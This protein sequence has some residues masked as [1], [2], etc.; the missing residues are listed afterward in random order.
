M[1]ATKTTRGVLIAALATLFALL[2]T[3]AASAIVPGGLVNAGCVVN[4]GGG[5]CGTAHN[6]PSGSPPA[7]A[8]SP[9]G[10]NV[11]VAGQDA[12]GGY[13]LITFARNPATG[14]LTQLG[15]TAGCI[16][17]T[18]ITNVCATTTPALNAPSSI[19]ITPDGSSVYVA[20]AG[21]SNILEFD[22]GAGGVLSLKSTPCIAN[23]GGPSQTCLDA[24]AMS[25]PQ[26]LAVVGSQL[27][28]VSSGSGAVTAL[29][30]NGGG[31]LTQIPTTTLPSGCVSNSLLDGCA[32]YAALGG[33]RWIAARPDALYVASQT[34]RTIAVIERDPSTGLMAPRSCVSAANLLCA[35]K[36]PADFN[37]NLN[38]LV[39]SPGGQ[40]YASV[41]SGRVVA[42]DPT[43]GPGLAR[44]AGAGGCVA[45]AA[46]ANSCTAGRQFASPYALLATADGEDV[47][48]TSANAILEL[49]RAADGSI[50][51]RPDNRGCL[52]S[53]ATTSLC[54]NTPSLAPGTSAATASRDDHFLYVVASTG[55]INAFKRDSSSPVCGNATVTVNVGFQGPL[56]IP[57]SDE[58]GDPLS[59]S[60]VNAPTLG[61]TGSIDNAAAKI[62]YSAPAAQNGTTTFTIRAAYTSFATFEAIGSITVNVVGAPALVPAGVD[63][64]KDGFFAG[65][66]CNDGNAAIRP[67][68]MEIKGNRI[69][70]NCDGLAEGFPLIPVGVSHGWGFKKNSVI[71]TLKSLAI[72]QSSPAGMKVKI[73]C[74]GKKCPFKSK[75]LK[76]AK[77]KKGSRSVL[78]SLTRKQRRFRAG[79]TIE[80][81]VSAPD[82]NTKVARLPLKKGKSPVAQALCVAP[83][84]SKPEK[85]CS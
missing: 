6:L 11:Y 56:D 35:T 52:Y 51:A 26:D 77:A 31:V 28:V 49:D 65:Q 75:A 54:A 7:I 68:A 47:Y 4:G 63:A 10:A 13:S 83:G 33:A 16:R 38:G 46:V 29:Q 71:L 15:G 76:P 62:N 85:S 39:L 60:V 53:G 30:I 24:D 20:N 43:A 37:D 48:A 50:A 55:R 82:F 22:R 44:R 40:V 21:T 5:G 64:D 69:D 41:N 2:G 42:L 80:V 12:T 27:Y 73:L 34:G 58:D 1:H 67:G 45:S 61:A 19:A 25:G 18:A 70:E 66:D 78:A 59:Y 72:T 23:S 74:K 57:C 32:T 81:W 8:M 14:G 17:T 84:Q 36:L 9:D 3:S 79:Q